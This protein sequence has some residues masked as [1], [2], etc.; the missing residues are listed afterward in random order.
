MKWIMFILTILI[1]S[2]WIGSN[3]VPSFSSYK[4]KASA[5]PIP[6]EQKSP[7]PPPPPLPEV[8][9]FSWHLEGLK[10]ILVVDLVIKNKSTVTWK[11]MSV[12]CDGYAKSG[13]MIGSSGGTVYDIV[14]PGKEL[15]V[16][17][18]NMGFVNTQTSSANCAVVN[19]VEVK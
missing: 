15:K 12:I 19:A 9:N 3:S 10:N 16:K 1:L 5:Q 8:T 6:V 18:L 13:T 17:G 7:P 2:S 11:D 4:E 14:K